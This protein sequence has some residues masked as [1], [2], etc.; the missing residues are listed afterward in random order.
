MSP[1]CVV[2]VFTAMQMTHNYAFQQSLN[3]QNAL[4]SLVFCLSAIKNWMNNIFLKLKENTHTYTQNNFYQASRPKRCTI[5]E[6]LFPQIK[7]EVILKACVFEFE[8]SFKWH[9]SRVAKITF[10]HLIISQT[11][12]KCWQDTGTLKLASCHKA[13]SCF[14][15]KQPI[16]TFHWSS[17]KG[18]LEDEK[19]F[20]ILLLDFITKQKRARHELHWHP[21]SL[22]KMLEKVLLLS[23]QALMVQY[24]T[25][26]TSE[27]P[28]RQGYVTQ[29]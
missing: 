13:N 22:K 7:S 3:E 6:S 27:N 18:Y 23:Y 20:T 19:L 10:F 15:L 26:L 5:Q 21:V 24:Q 25:V 1:E 11:C 17:L 8:L 29:N 28:A 14:H 16:L 12:E 9:I 2:S 4:S